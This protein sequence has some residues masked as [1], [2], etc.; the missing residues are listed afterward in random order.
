MKRRQL[1]LAC[2]ATVCA[3]VLSSSSARGQGVETQTVAASID[4]L[5]GFTQFR[6]Q[7]IPQSMLADAQAV[8]II[9]N[10]VKGGF[11][12]AGRFGRGV[13]LVRDPNGA[14]RA[15]LF[16]TFTGGS[17]G[18]QLG[19][20]STDVVLVFKN[21]KG[22]EAMLTGS[23][24]TLGADAAVAAGPVGRQAT[25]GTDIKLNAEIYSYSRSRGLFAGVAL[26]GSVLKVDNRAVAA[27]YAN[28]TFV[29]P[30]A[31]QL[32]EMV[33]RDTAGPPPVAATT[34]PAVNFVPTPVAAAPPAEQLRQAVVESSRRLDPLVDDTWKRYLALPVPTMAN[35]PASAAEL[36][37]ALIRYDRI[38]TDPQYRV[39]ADRP[40]FHETHDLLRRYVAAVNAASAPPAGSAMPA[41]SNLPPP[42]P[43]TAPASPSGALPFG[44]SPPPALP[45]VAPPTVV[46][47][48][49]A[50][51]AAPQQ[52]ILPLR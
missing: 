35:Q 7:S 49:T 8:A 15:P 16:V 32:V 34:V 12:I 52:S 6:A 36:D 26:D 30:Q 48:A 39:L 38:T 29:P 41:L 11:I 9:P 27:Y 40:E 10:V 46:P 24:F 44:A 33:T 45:P 14:W 20:Q 37:A 1:A 22:V 19:L 17:V 18:W 21:R 51:P 43:H 50:P 4:V 13:L 5:Q 23:E 25:A 3:F 42:P 2:A 47:G 31:Q 28:G